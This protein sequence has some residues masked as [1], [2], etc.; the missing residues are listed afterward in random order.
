MFGVLVATTN[1]FL[2]C[3]QAQ[4]RAGMKPDELEED[5]EEED[6]EQAVATKQEEEAED[7]EP[8][9]AILPAPDLPPTP[10]VYETAGKQYYM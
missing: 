7:R 5:V 6:G 3:D 4:V 1:W 9:P 10:A 8:L 2:E